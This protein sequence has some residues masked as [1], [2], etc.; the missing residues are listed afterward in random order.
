MRLITSVDSLQNS[1]VVLLMVGSCPS[2]YTVQCKTYLNTAG[3]Y[4]DVIDVRV[5]SGSVLSADPVMIQEG[6]KRLQTLNCALSVG[7]V[8]KQNGPSHGSRD[9]HMDGQ[10][11]GRA[12]C[13]RVWPPVCLIKQQQAN[14]IIR[15]QEVT[16]EYNLKAFCLHR[17]RKAT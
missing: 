11:D 7:S 15:S 16:L 2:Q 13:D 9:F 10:R 1:C 5:R 12:G 4:E 3:V 6:Q 8:L 17:R 14:I